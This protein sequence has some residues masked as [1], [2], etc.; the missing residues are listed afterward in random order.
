[1]CQQRESPNLPHLG[2]QVS[3]HG[4]S[5]AASRPLSCQWNLRLVIW[6]E[7][8]MKDGF[9]TSLRYRH[10]LLWRWMVRYQIISPAPF[11][12]LA[13]KRGKL[14]ME[15]MEDLALLRLSVSWCIRGW[16]GG[17]GR[18]LLPI[19]EGGRRRRALMPVVKLSHRRTC[20]G[21]VVWL[22]WS[23]WKQVSSY[24][25]WEVLKWI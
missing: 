16:S 2:R 23:K 19:Q 14:E 20:A 11:V 1:M 10:F 18:R 17:L 6:E 3:L 7:T 4:V 25:E 24:R 21:V 5:R 15:I 13:V 22:E 9:S 8:P 12:S